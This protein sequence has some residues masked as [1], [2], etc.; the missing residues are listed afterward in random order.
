VGG[1]QKSHNEGV[2]QSN[3]WLVA[4]RN[5]ECKGGKWKGGDGELCGRISV[6]CNINP[7]AN[8]LQVAQCSL[9]RQTTL[10]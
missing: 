7:L 10:P 9:K 3:E 2:G 8:T 4:R 6:A 1:N 5:R